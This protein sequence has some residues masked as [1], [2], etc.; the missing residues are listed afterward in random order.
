MASTMCLYY[1][2]GSRGESLEE[3][4]AFEKPVSTLGDFL[5]HFPTAQ[6]GLHFRF[7][8]DDQRSGYV[9]KDVVDPK[10][11]LPKYRGRVCAQVLRL[12]TM[13]A[14][15]PQPT[16]LKKKAVDKSAVLRYRA[17]L[18]DVTQKQ[19]QRQRQQLQQ[20]QR[21]QAK[22]AP[23]PN[24]PT[25]PPR[26]APPPAP[27]AAS[28]QSPDFM[29][30]APDQK[31]AP[32]AASA[33]PT[34]PR[35]GV[36]QDDIDDDDDIVAPGPASPAAA[37]AAAPGFASDLDFMMGQ[38]TP[39]EAQA[40]AKRG[41]AGGD[42]AEEEELRMRHRP[43]IRNWA[44]QNGKPKPLMNLLSTLDQVLYPGAKW[45]GYSIGDLL[46]PKKVRQMRDARG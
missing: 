18:A 3:P 42:D 6:E 28:P 32:A 36:V 33:T 31:S 37:P 34:P 46:E 4:N 10:E 40:E 25:A 44:T 26:R 39:V 1:Y 41:A 30:F 45:K 19:R 22:Q 15:E 35:P 24:G 7:Q 43:R 8:V 11:V 13:N 2:H 17:A 16:S 20:Q 38:K 29:A 23:A 14:G 12:S 5:L 21:Q 27:P 9:W